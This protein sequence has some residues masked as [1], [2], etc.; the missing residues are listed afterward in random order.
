MSL[1]LTRE[2]EIKATIKSTEF[3]LSE[4]VISFHAITPAGSPM[5][6]FG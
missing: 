4:L 5:T 2:L 3:I 6:C 1:C